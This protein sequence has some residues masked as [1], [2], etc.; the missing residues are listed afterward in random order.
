VRPVEVRSLVGDSTKLQQLTGWQ[1]EYDL[2]MM[3]DDV[4]AVARRATST[5]PT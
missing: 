2:D 4:L 3:L 5:A 1:P